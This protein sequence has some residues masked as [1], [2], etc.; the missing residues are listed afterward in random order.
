MKVVG[1]QLVEQSC[2]QFVHWQAANG[3]K[4]P[5]AAQTFGKALNAWKLMNT[6]ITWLVEEKMFTNN[7]LEKVWRDIK[8]HNLLSVKRK[9]LI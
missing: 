4:W 8:V 2:W 9:V 6:M 1:R 7:A 3:R 5:G